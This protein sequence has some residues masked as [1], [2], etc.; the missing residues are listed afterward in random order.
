MPMNADDLDKFLADC[1]DNRI[2]TIVDP[3]AASFITL[4]QKR[5]GYRVSHADNNVSDG[6]RE[7][8]TAM[9]RGLIKISPGCLNWTKEAQG[10]C[11]DDT[12][13][14]DRPIKVNDHA[15]DDT[16]YFVKTMRIA[17]PKRQG[18]SLFM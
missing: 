2:R 6:I 4:L 15:M 1:P 10:Y 11:W 3:S 14:V 17:Q 16:R 18:S 8:A 13:G 5:G 9:K 7:T 12:A